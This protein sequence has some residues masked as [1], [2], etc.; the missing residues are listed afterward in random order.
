MDLKAK[1]F[2]LSDEDIKWVE[3]TKASLT[4]DEKLG[5]LFF[6]IGYSPNEQY[7]QYEILSKNPG[8]LM[9]RTGKT[10]E[11]FD[12]YSYLQTNS[13]VPMLL[14]ANLE[15]GGD[16]IVMEGTAFGKQMQVAATGDPK[17]A[18][19]LAR[20]SCSEGQAVGCNYAFAP[21]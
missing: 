11:L 13:K 14:A 16:G 3:E 9:F 20:V 15:A 2:Y 21:V 5:Q 19:R 12:A 6:P 18:Y 4:L 1:P 8:G 10:Q 7:L 17:Q